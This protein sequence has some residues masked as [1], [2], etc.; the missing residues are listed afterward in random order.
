MTAE[1]KGELTRW[2]QHGDKGWGLGVVAVDGGPPVAVTGVIVGARVG[3][4]IEASG[5]HE[6]HPKYGPQFRVT[7]AV[8]SP[9]QSIDGV[10][11]WL[12]DTLPNIG[13]RRA[14]AMVEHFGGPAAMWLVIEHEPERLTE[15]QGI[16]S[17]RARDIRSAYLSGRDERDHQIQLRAWGLTD[18][19]VH[20]CIRTW[21][22][23]EHACTVIR[24]DPYEL[25]R[26]V[27]GFGW[28]RADAVAAR[29]GIPRDAPQR[30]ATGLAY[31]LES[32]CD[33]GHVYMLPRAFQAGAERVLGLEPSL[34]LTGIR[35]A[36]RNAAIIKRGGRVY[37]AAS[38]AWESELH[39]HLTE[40]LAS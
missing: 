25:Y 10:A 21:L 13:P 16:T 23:A 14:R 1:L 33:D 27:P 29:S 3:D 5:T 4:R 34:V 31:T 19:Q 24:A 6:V 15:V 22:T 38:E 30:I 9:P 11:A 7:R 8:L 35:T 28:S 12:V 18:A 2:T 36:V 37:S 26:H 32:H 17:E 39:G 20:R 40:R